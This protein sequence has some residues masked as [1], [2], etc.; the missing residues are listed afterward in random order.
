[1]DSE[2]NSEESNIGKDQIG[3]PAIK[4]SKQT[5]IIKKIFTMSD[6]LIREIDNYVILEPG[7]EERFLTSEETLTWLENL[8]KNMTELPLDLKNKKTLKDYSIDPNNF[9]YSFDGEN[10][11]P[12][13]LSPIF[14]N[15]EVLDKYKND[16]K[17]QGSR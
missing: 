14:F 10:E 4:K 13:E 12:H 11:L 9:C 7:K 2:L 5:Q 1:M 6:P 17:K 8:L 15:D 3:L 16:S